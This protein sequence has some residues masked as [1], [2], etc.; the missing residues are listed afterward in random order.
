M[1]GGCLLTFL[2]LYFLRTV[3]TSFIAVRYVDKETDLV[4]RRNMLKNSSYKIAEKG[5][6]QD[7]Y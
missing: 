4:S 3:G 2:W 5:P 7:N 1:T 6:K